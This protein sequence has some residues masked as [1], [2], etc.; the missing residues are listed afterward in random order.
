LDENRQ[1]FLIIPAIPVTNFL[2][3][4]RPCSLAP[5]ILNFRSFEMTAKFEALVRDLVRN[6]TFVKINAKIDRQAV[7]NPS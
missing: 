7:F 1:I 5:Q 2:S 4:G 3:F 6:N